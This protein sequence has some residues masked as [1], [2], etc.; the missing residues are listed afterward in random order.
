MEL[1]A[2]GLRLLFVGGLIDRKGP[3]VL[4]SA[5]L[6]VFAGRDDVTLVVK[7]FGADGIYPMSDR[8]RLRDYAESGRARASST[9]TAT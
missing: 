7:D 2:P 5:F 8:S 3:D 6:D 9:C 4:I 1:D